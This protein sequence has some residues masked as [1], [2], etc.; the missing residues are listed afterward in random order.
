MKR[1]FL[2][3][4]GKHIEVCIYKT[5]WI[6]HAASLKMYRNGILPQTTH[7]ALAICCM[8]YDK[9]EPNPIVAVIMMSWDTI[10][11]E[12]IGHELLHAAIHLHNY[13]KQ[14]LL[15]NNE[16]LTTLHSDLIG[17]LMK[18]FSKKEMELIQKNAKMNAP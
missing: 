11:F 7:E 6:M 12:I 13:T 14:K 9:G 4:K 8:G 1:V 18:T 10:S 15:K 16:V 3:A 5:E 17:A 2:Q